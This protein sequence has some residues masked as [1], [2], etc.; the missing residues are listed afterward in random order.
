MPSGW[1]KVFHN[2]FQKH[3]SFGYSDISRAYTLT[4]GTEVTMSAIRDRVRRFVE[5]GFMSGSADS[6]FTFTPLAVEKFG[7][8]KTSPNENG[9]TEVAPEAEGIGVAAPV[10]S[11]SNPKPSW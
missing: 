3:Q 2:I 10:S 1:R 11:W 6:G 4:I 7:L 8:D 9:A 5:Q